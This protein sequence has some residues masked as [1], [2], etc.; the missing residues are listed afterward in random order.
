MKCAVKKPV[1]LRLC[2]QTKC[3][4][5]LR[6]RAYL[7]KCLETRRSPWIRLNFKRIAETFGVTDRTLRRAKKRLEQDNDLKFR[8]L[9][10]SSG[11]GWVV[12][13][14]LESKLLWDKEPLFYKKHQ[15]GFRSRNVRDRHCG[16]DIE[17]VGGRF[18]LP[19]QEGVEPTT[20]GF[21][22]QRS[23]LLT[24]QRIENPC[25]SLRN[26][27]VQGTWEQPS[28]EVGLEP[29]TYW[30]TANRSTIEL[31]R[32]NEVRLKMPVYTY[33]TIPQKK[34]QKDDPNRIERLPSKQSVVELSPKSFRAPACHA[35]GWSNGADCKSAGYAMSAVAEAILA[36]RQGA[37]ETAVLPKSRATSEQLTLNQLVLGLN[38]SG[39]TSPGIE[40]GTHKPEVSRAYLLRHNDGDRGRAV[41]EPTANG[42][43]GR[44]S[45]IEL[46]DK[47]NGG[48]V[49]EFSA[50][51]ET[52]DNGGGGG[53][54]TP[55]PIKTA[56]KSINITPAH[57][58]GHNKNNIVG[59]YTAD[60]E[61]AANLAMITNSLHPSDQR[62]GRPSGYEP[63]ELGR[64]K[65]LVV[66]IHRINP[67]QPESQSGCR[68]PHIIGH[69]KSLT[70]IPL[71][72]ERVPKVRTAV[73]TRT[74]RS[75][76]WLLAASGDELRRIA[77]RGQLRL[78]YFEAR[79]AC[80]WHI[81]DNCKVKDQPEVAKSLWLAGLLAGFTPKT[82][83]KAF[84]KALEYAHGTATDVGLISGNP[85]T[86]FEMS[87]VVSHAKKQLQNQI[88]DS[89]Y[90]H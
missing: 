52:S 31:L 33:E 56:L 59:E 58:I 47:G 13:V 62:T 10:K 34:G 78:A 29:T 23:I 74:Q 40:R 38:P 2:R 39:T 7:I 24:K 61:S 18:E 15:D 12:I 46:L 36:P 49:E 6:L 86:K 84:C 75:R 32:N 44:C 19:Y 68:E 45:T 73:R 80:T 51:L 67:Q 43:K 3:P 35:G 79:S 48:N 55:V 11:S 16:R 30:L 72:R 64:C 77:S 9:S 82:I 42:L 90:Q 50:V 14:A 85:K 28:L 26:I 83:E 76:R 22:G 8:T 27:S 88:P 53:S 54:R 81:W 4:T 20:P 41:L 69:D 5:H 71:Y 66:S 60:F 21:G 89:T 70:D 37:S 57:V 63:D 17:R 1:Q 65:N 25:P 87:L